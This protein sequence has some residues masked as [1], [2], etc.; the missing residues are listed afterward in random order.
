MHL[1]LGMAGLI[2]PFQISLSDREGLRV[3]RHQPAKLAAIG[4]LW[5][6]VIRYIATLYFEEK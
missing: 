4:L 3:H 2:A 1:A 5:F 6:W